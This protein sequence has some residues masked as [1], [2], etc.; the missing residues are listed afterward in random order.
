MSRIVLTGISLNT[1]FGAGGCCCYNALIVMSELC[2]II[3]SN[4]NLAAY[5]ALR[6]L[7]ETL[8]GTGGSY[9]RK[10][11][12]GVR[13][14]CHGL[15]VAILAGAGVGLLTL[16]TAGGLLCDLFG[17]LMGMLATNIRKI[18]ELFKKCTA[19]KRNHKSTN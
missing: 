4:E 19:R 7:G 11:L 18:N 1:L 6:A 12:V 15:G 16:F 14:L 5:R 8:F 10:L 2:N 17:V 13:K 3:L 9:R